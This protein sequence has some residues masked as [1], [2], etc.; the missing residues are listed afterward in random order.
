L[1]VGS[2]T[3]AKGGWEVA[4]GLVA[5]LDW[6]DLEPFLVVGLV[7]VGLVCA[8]GGGDVAGGS[9]GRVAEVAGLVAVLATATTPAAAAARDELG[10]EAGGVDL[11]W[12]GGSA[13]V[14]WAGDIAMGFGSWS[15]GWGTGCWGALLVLQLL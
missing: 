2:G 5:D 7:V 1:R 6:V 14:P 4:T 15:N 9:A 8:C 11:L 12:A 10:G 13:V 3:E